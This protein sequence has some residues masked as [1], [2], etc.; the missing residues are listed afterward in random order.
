MRWRVVSIDAVR[1]CWLVIMRAVIFY[2]EFAVR[3][4][5][6]DQRTDTTLIRMQFRLQGQELNELRQMLYYGVLMSCQWKASDIAHIAYK[7]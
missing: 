6:P 5:A 4:L 3:T 2:A 1:D 7:Q